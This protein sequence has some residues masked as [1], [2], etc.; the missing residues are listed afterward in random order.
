MSSKY[1]SIDSGPWTMGFMRTQEVATT[2]INKS[3]LHVFTEITFLIEIS[4]TCPSL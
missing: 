2:I 1:L 3:P 4:S